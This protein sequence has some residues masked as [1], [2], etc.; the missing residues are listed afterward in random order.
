MSNFY[1]VNL[2]SLFSNKPF[3]GWGRKRTGKFAVLLSKLFARK[4]VLF[5]DGFIRSI[6]LGID[7]CKSFSVVEDDI[8]IYYD[9]TTSSKLENILNFHTFSLDELKLGTKAISLIKEYK[10]SKYNNATLTLPK[11]LNS[12][13]KKIL[14]IA[15]TK[16]DMSLKYGMA[17]KFDTKE[18]IQDA[19]I[20]NPDSEVYLK[21]HPDVISG[22]KESNI[23]IEYA[24]KYCTIITENINPIVLLE[25]FDKVY[26]Q[27]SQMGFEALLL[28]KEVV[29]YGMP[30]YAGWGLTID[31]IDCKRRIR[32]ISL[33]ELFVGAYILY[34]K[35][36]NPYTQQESNIVDTILDI[37]KRRVTSNKK[38]LYDY[39]CIGDSHIRVFESFLFKLLPYKMHS[40]YVAGATAYGIENIHS[41]TKAYYKF[42]ECIQND[43]FKNIIVS[44][45]E[46]DTSYTLWKVALKR[47]KDVY[48]MIEVSIQRYIKFLEL[49]AT[50]GKVYVLDTALPTVKDG[51]VCDDVVSGV[52]ESI[53]ISREEKIKLNLF[54]SR[55]IKEWC[56]KRED[57]VFINTNRYILKDKDIRSIYLPKNKC[58][59]HYNRLSFS[60]L[61]FYLF[62]R[63][64]FHG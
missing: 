37:Y 10:I 30:F 25:K 48:Q 50:Y 23:D 57:I 11:Y 45:G 39:L 52:R 27:T 59:H 19:I 15:Q 49:L 8:G 42:M 64:K 44:L 16:G 14:I 61:L 54:F 7:G 31:K 40:C 3:Y 35:Y 2:L 4:C 53:E 56:D 5:E 13:T 38:V 46:V 12:D 62:I 28:D 47:D 63:G 26:T 43:N 21:V 60:L 58:N 6:G 22:K 24:K 34:T 9:A 51:T 36:V 29:V 18:M 41:K 32:N 55:H 33:E 17:E 1:F 20:D